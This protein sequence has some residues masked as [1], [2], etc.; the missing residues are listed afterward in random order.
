MSDLTRRTAENQKVSAI[1]SQAPFRLKKNSLEGEPHQKATQLS[2]MNEDP[3]KNTRVGAY[4][5]PHL[6]ATDLAPP[7]SVFARTTLRLDH[8]VKVG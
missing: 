6:R 5:L 2:G 7:R 4:A 3:A 8:E 1:A